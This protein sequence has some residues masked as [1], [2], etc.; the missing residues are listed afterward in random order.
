MSKTDVK[1][2]DQTN[3]A[4]RKRFTQMKFLEQVKYVGKVIVCLLTFGF[5][6]P[7]IFSE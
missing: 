2:P 1:Q 6:Y 4:T 5:V 7:H 3:V